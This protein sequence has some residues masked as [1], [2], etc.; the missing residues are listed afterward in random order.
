VYV[1]VGLG[2]FFTCRCTG[3]VI[4]VV[5]GRVII[6]VVLHIRIT[7]IPG[8]AGC[9]TT[10]Y[11]QLNKHSRTTE[12]GSSSSLGFERRANNASS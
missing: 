12:K 1:S 2:G 7:Y 8:S 5:E 3:W 10:R 4:V 6:G 9:G 11:V